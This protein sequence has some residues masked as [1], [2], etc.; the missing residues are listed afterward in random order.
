MKKFLYIL[1]GLIL[2]IVIIAAIG[3]DPEEESV[4][5][6]P[7][8]TEEGVLEDEIFEVGDS[9]DHENRILTVD[10]VERGWVSP[11]EFDTPSEGE[12][13][14]LVE[15]TLQNESEEEVSFNPLHFEL[16]D[17]GGVIQNY[18]AM[19]TGV[20][21]LSSGG[22][23]PGG[24]ISGNLVFEVNENNLEELTLFYEPGFWGDDRV[25]VEL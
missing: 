16:K 7:T 15:L 14:V 2:V 8:E 11:N 6:D 24:E 10:S 17:G 5:D 4:A 22:L 19:V 13:Y 25:E 12:A 21:T 9:I 18:G 23:A 1:G 20:D 3:G